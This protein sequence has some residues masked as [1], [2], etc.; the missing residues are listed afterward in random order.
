MTVPTARHKNDGP[1]RKRIMVPEALNELHLKGNG[2]ML[3]SSLGQVVEAHATRSEV[4]VSADCL[5]S[6]LGQVVP[7]VAVHFHHEVSVGKIKVHK[8]WAKGFVALELV[9]SECQCPGN[10]VLQAGRFCQSVA[11]LGAV[12]APSRPWPMPLHLEVLATNGADQ[13]YP[14]LSQL[15]EAAPGAE[16]TD[17]TSYLVG[18]PIDGDPAARARHRKAAT[19]SPSV[20][21][22]RAIR[23][24]IW[25]T[26][27]TDKLRA[28]PL[29]RPPTR[30]ADTPFH[31]IAIISQLRPTRYGRWAKGTANKHGGY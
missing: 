20:T 10:K 8:V 15:I 30:L 6:L 29:E 25:S 24:A 12:A 5:R 7:V 11:L 23:T 26:A 31:T 17:A 28:F 2:I 16:P 4:G 22:N 18:H 13:V 1:M 9:A 21:A 3:D 14:A 19:V 27:R